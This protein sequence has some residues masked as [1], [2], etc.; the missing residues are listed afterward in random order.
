[1]SAVH[2]LH[3]NLFSGGI[4]LCAKKMLYC[5]SLSHGL[6]LVS[7]ATAYN[8]L[9]NNTGPHWKQDIF[10][11]KCFLKVDEMQF[12]ELQACLTNFILQIRLK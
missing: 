8:V 4:L 9:S 12:L 6:N 3:V 2:V 7:P 11:A 10:L 5:L 1:M